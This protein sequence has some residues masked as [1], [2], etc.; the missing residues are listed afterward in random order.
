MQSTGEQVRLDSLKKGDV[1]EDV[2]G[3]LWQFD[4]VNRS[5]TIHVAAWGREG[6]DDFCSFALVRKIERDLNDA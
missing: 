2:I 6:F 1:F 3:L 4:H 5:G